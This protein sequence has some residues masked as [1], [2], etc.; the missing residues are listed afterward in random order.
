MTDKQKQAIKILNQ[1]RWDN[2]INENNY[3]LLL[4]FV[5]EQR[6]ESITPALYPWTKLTESPQPLDPIRYN[7]ET[8]LTKE[9]KQ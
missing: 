8:I 3:F 2:V 7:I 5:V 9:D 4:E 1:L 6:V